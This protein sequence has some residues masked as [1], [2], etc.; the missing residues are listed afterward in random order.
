MVGKMT[1]EDANLLIRGWRDENSQLRVI[2]R[3]SRLRFGA[4]CKAI[5]AHDGTV[6]FRVG[7]DSRDVI[8]FFIGDCRCG[9]GDAPPDDDALKVGG[10]VESVLI[11]S[12]PNFEL[13]I[14][15]LKC[16]DSHQ[17]E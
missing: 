3:S 6:A 5:D 12:R 8:E 4:F 7:S 1:I 11:A 10:K 9:F 2:L 13:F 15:L 17:S 14:I 16:E